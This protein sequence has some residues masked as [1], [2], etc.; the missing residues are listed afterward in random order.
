MLADSCSSKQD[1]LGG[2]DERVHFI[3]SK[4]LTKVRK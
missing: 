1:G 4:H 3:N 2:H